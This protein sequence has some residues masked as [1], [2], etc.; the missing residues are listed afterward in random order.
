[1][2][3]TPVNEQEKKV[4]G[5]GQRIAAAIGLISAAAPAIIA[6][7]GGTDAITDNIGLLSTGLGSLVAGGIA[8][9]VAVRR[10]T[11]K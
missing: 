4:V 1:M 2:D 8:S 9:Y 3:I 11:R 7:V 10:M 5:A 6:A